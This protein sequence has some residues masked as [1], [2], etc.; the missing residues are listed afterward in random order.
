MNIN[1]IRL[2]KQIIV[3]IALMVIMILGLVSILVYYLLQE[4]IEKSGRERLVQ[5][6]Q[7]LPLFLEEESRVIEATLCSLN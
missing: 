2:R 7:L 5:V 3:P 6:Q 1:E 4:H